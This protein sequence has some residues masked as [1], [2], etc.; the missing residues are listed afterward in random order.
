MTPLPSK[1]R[2]IV[3]KYLGKV[4]GG[5][6]FLARSITAAT[7]SLAQ[8]LLVM[9]YM[10]MGDTISRIKESLLQKIEADAKAANADAQKKLAEAAIAANVANL[11]KRKDVIARL[12]REKKEA[13]VAKTKAEAEALLKDAETRRLQALTE[14]KTRFLEAVAKLRQ[15]GGDI[16]IDPDNLLKIIGA[17]LPPEDDEDESDNNTT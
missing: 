10:Y 7:L 17:G 1:I 13:E 16:Y 15:E 4:L 2:N 5:P 3:H 9:F 6:K 12:E 14:A 8:G 11:P